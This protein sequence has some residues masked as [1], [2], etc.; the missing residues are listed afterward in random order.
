MKA[1]RVDAFGPPAEVVR[2]LEVPE[3]EPPRE[4][5]VL[6]SVE[7]T[8]I[9]PS[10]LRILSGVHGALPSTPRHPRFTVASNVLSERG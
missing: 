8:P 6:V 7:A 2:Y 3:P 1:S 9:H 10:D 5:E 4:G